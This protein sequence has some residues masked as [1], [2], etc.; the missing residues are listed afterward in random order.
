MN[1]AVVFFVNPCLGGISRRRRK[2]IRKIYPRAI[3]CVLRSSEAESK[4]EIK[5]SFLDLKFSRSGQGS[6]DG[7][8]RPRRPFGVVE[9][10]L[11]LAEARGGSPLLGNI[12]CRSMRLHPNARP[13]LGKPIPRRTTE[14]ALKLSA[15]AVTFV[16]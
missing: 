9:M 4:S 14:S 16:E 12:D 5:P 2:T 8:G 6:L 1:F 11:V 3:L 10:G 15:D 7:V 13:T